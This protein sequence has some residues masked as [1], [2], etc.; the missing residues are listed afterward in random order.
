MTVSKQASL[1]KCLLIYSDVI[2]EDFLLDNYIFNEMG[3]WLF[4]CFNRHLCLSS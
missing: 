3:I 4:D 2:N 1:E